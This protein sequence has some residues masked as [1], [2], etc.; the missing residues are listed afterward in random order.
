MDQ[1]KIRF[2]NPSK[3]FHEVVRRKSVLQEELVN[4]IP[5]IIREQ[6]PPPA[7]TPRRENSPDLSRFTPIQ[8]DRIRRLRAQ[9]LETQMRDRRDLP[10]EDD[11]SPVIITSDDDD[12]DDD[13]NDQNGPGRRRVGIENPPGRPFRSGQPIRSSSRVIKQEPNDEL[14]AQI[15][16]PDGRDVVQGDAGHEHGHAVG[17]DNSNLLDRQM[18]RA[19][20][21]LQQQTQKKSSVQKKRSLDIDQKESPQQKRKAIPLREV[22]LK[23]S[24]PGFQD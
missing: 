9:F 4:L 20:K 8:R 17:E 7:Q 23:D 16:V 11:D 18:E 14:V 22:K 21:R 19:R 24:K 2:E 5:K 13:P 3:I 12:D 15:I 1:A 10:S 6:A